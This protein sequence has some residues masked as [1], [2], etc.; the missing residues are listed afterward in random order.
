M[1]QITI[2]PRIKPEDRSCRKCQRQ[3]EIGET[4]MVQ[5]NQSGKHYCMICWNKICI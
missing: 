1:K 4:V 5:R 2:T 3:L